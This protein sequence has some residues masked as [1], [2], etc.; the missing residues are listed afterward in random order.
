MYEWLL[1]HARQLG[2]NGGSAF[3]AIAGFGRDGRMREQQFFEL[4][5]EVPVLV[6]FIAGEAEADALL[7]ALNKENVNLFY[8]RMAA[9]FDVIG[10]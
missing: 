9:E 3:R 10:G 1:E 5:G 8:A 6:E 4:A 7:A 2:I